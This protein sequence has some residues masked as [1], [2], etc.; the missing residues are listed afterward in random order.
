[1]RHPD[2]GMAAGQKSLPGGMSYAARCKGD[3][4]RV[5]ERELRGIFL[6]RI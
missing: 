4:L 6:G 3:R 2:K 5:R 1:M